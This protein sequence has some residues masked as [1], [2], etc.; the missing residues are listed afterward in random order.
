MELMLPVGTSLSFI[1]SW[2]KSL[3]ILWKTLLLPSQV[4]KMSSTNEGAGVSNADGGALGGSNGISPVAKK[5]IICGKDA[6]DAA[7]SKKPSKVDL[8]SLPTKQYLDQ[9]VVPILLQGLQ[10]LAKERPSDPI[11]YLAAYLLKNKSQYEGSS[12]Q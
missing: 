8:M 1:W 2:P 11:N 12:S 10:L 4:I 3:G 7:V 5:V 9:T 6:T